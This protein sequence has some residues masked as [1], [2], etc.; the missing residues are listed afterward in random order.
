MEVSSK[1]PSSWVFALFTPEQQARCNLSTCPRVSLVPSR[2]KKGGSKLL[3]GPSKLIRAV[4]NHSL[5]SSERR[6][7]PPP[8]SNY[9]ASPLTMCP[10][11]HEFHQGPLVGI[12]YQLGGC[13]HQQLLRW[14]LQNET[15]TKMDFGF[16]LVALRTQPNSAFPQEPGLQISPSK[17]LN[18]SNLSN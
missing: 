4:N 8:Y 13:V 6:S 7:T 1:G 16:F 11:G 3:L 15:P 9:S 17:P 5:L 12:I 10:N 14:F 18:K 2:Q